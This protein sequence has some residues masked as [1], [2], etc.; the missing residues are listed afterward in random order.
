MKNLIV[1]FDYVRMG[2][3]LAEMSRTYKQKHKNCQ[4]AYQT[5]LELLK[6]NPN[7]PQ[8]KAKHPETDPVLTQFKPGDIVILYGMERKCCINIVA[9]ELIQN[10]VIVACSIDGTFD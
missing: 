8:V 1:H 10:N 4:T 5:I 9:E 7:T 3:T 6:E 2:V